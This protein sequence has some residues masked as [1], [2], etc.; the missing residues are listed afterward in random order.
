MGEY[1]PKLLDFHW[2]K[3]NNIRPSPRRLWWRAL[4]PTDRIPR[5]PIPRLHLIFLGRCDL[6][7][8]F[9]EI[10][11]DGINRPLHAKIHRDPIAGRLRSLKC[12]AIRRRE[13]IPVIPIIDLRQIR[14]RPRKRRRNSRKIPPI[15]VHRIIHFLSHL[16][17]PPLENCLSGKQVRLP[18]RPYPYQLEGIAFLMPRHAALLADEMGLGKT[19]QAILA[20]RLLFHAGIV[21]WLIMRRLRSRLLEE[22]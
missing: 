2:R 5:L 11:L 21:G 22:T 9:Q 12:A 13:V 1:N 16:L 20:L 18:F 4:L 15:V 14:P 19:A 7:L 10:N 3:S 6:L 8:I 17:Q